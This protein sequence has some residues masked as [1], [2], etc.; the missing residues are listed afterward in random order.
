MEGG[1]VEDLIKKFYET[2]KKYHRIKT[3][4]DLYL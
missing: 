2:R 1:K 4:K 3:L